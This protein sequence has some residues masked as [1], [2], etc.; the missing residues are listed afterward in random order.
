MSENSQMSMTSYRNK[1][2]LSNIKS[3]LKFK[4][5]V[6]FSNYKNY[7]SEADSVA[8]EKRSDTKTLDPTVDLEQKIMQ[9]IK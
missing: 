5:G 3:G 4:G 7:I 8:E 6:D 2:L 1:E 9:I